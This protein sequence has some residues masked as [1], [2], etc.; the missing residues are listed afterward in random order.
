MKKDQK[1]QEILA[2]IRE[3]KEAKFLSYQAIVDITEQNGEA[4][5]LSTVKRLFAKDADI[6]DFRYHQTIRPVV[7]AVL[8]LDED[9][10]APAVVPDQQQAEQYYTTIEAMKAVMDYKHEQLMERTAEVERLKEQLKETTERHTKEIEELKADTQKKVE[11]LKDQIA[12][13]RSIND[14]NA[15]IIDKLMEK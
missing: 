11:H 4:V 15:R 9:T 6:S 5:S 2:K 7:R 14:R 1:M 3:A 13:L 10:E 8:G 12:Y